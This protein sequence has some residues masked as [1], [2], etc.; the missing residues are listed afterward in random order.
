[1]VVAEAV[2]LAFVVPTIAVS[3]EPFPGIVP[4]AV[5]ALAGAIGFLGL[6][7]FYRALAG[8]TMSLVAP[9]AAVIGAGLPV[10]AGTVGGD[11]LS[12]NEAAG[13]VVALVAVALVSRPAADAGVGRGGLAL[14]L[15]AGAGFGGFFIVIDLAVRAG[16]ETWW[17]V[18]ASR[19][20]TVLAGCAV[21]LAQGRAR[22]IV[23]RASPIMVVCG[24]ADTLGNVLFLLTN[25]QG[26]LGIAAV[27]ASMYP[28]MTVLLAWL[29]LGERL[30]RIHVV[31]V[32]LVFVGIALIAGA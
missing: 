19:S 7:A 18:V 23:R 13:I 2:G 15:V 5:A 4:I 12:P 32:A 6:L 28:A 8:G 3:G 25:A 27:L 17:P 10:V 26:S 16:A 30:A 22:A 29:V 1:M 24:V 20:A 11:R 14:A 21:A 31:G 9:V